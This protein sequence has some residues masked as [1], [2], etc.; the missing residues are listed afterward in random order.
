ML[1][2]K[3]KNYPDGSMTNLNRELAIMIGFVGAFILVFAIWCILFKYFTDV[4]DKKRAAVMARGVEMRG[5]VR[6]RETDGVVRTAE[7]VVQDREGEG[8]VE[9]SSSRSKYD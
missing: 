2:P 4:E 9:E 3:T 7:T 1:N 6:H 5:G 8:Q